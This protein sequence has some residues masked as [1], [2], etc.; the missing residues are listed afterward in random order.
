M[1]V[2]DAYTALEVG[3]QMADPEEEAA[4]RRIEQEALG[5]K[6][7]VVFPQERSD[8]YDILSEVLLLLLIVK[9]W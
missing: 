3:A 5:D 9:C 4:R 6:S 7:S 1:K 2:H 8:K